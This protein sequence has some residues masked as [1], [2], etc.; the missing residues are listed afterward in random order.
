MFFWISYTQLL[1]IL[2]PFDERSTNSVVVMDNASIY[3]VDDVI[4]AICSIGALVR[5]YSPEYNPIECVFGEV[6]QYMQAND[7]FV[8][9]SLSIPTMLLMAL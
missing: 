7:L 3:H 5:F 9:K 4:V 8:D 1:P 2:R 6:K